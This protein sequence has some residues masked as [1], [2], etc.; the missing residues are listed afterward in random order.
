MIF[1]HH[2]HDYQVKWRRSGKNKYNG[3]YYYSKEIVH[4]IIPLVDTDRN[5]VTINQDGHC[6]DHSIVFI[7]NNLNPQR[8]N[9]LK[10]FKDVV[11]VCGVPETVDKVKHL[12]HAIYLPLSVD[13]DYVEK[14]ITEKTR[15]VAFVGRYAKRQGYDF[16]PGTDVIEGMPRDRMLKTM[17]KY[18]RVYA[19][20][21]C[22]IEALVLGC[23]ILP[24]DKR[25]PD[26]S[27]WRVLDNKTAAVMLQRELDKIDHVTKAQKKK[28]KPIEYSEKDYAPKSKRKKSNS[29]KCFNCS[30]GEYHGFSSIPKR[31]S[32]IYFFCPKFEHYNQYQDACDEFCEGYPIRYNDK[33]KLLC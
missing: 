6:Y 3:A 4:N 32:R 31:A 25:Y 21:R 33:G 7:H 12:G 23:E 26:P 2:A 9:W 24:Y 28:R 30:N 8:Y 29:N 19:V 11:L 14:F 10:K 5:W 13:V 20:G 16:E 1:D 27:L 15:D 17:A 18:K 22:A